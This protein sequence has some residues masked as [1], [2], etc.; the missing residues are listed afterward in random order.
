MLCLKEREKTSY[1]K[2]RAPAE[3]EEELG[4]E[5][6]EKTKGRAWEVGEVHESRELPQLIPLSCIYR[7]GYLTR[8]ELLEGPFV[9]K[10]LSWRGLW[11]SWSSWNMGW[12][13]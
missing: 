12:L 8:G 7:Y 4:E 5:L 13:Y 3:R 2:S 1:R 11:S 9:S 6:I 10:L